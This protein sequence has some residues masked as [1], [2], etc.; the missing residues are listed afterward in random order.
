MIFY[1]TLHEEHK[2]D[3]SKI[4]PNKLSRHEIRLETFKPATDD[5]PAV[6]EQSVPETLLNM[7]LENKEHYQSKKEAIHL[8]LTGIGDE[9][10]STV[11]ACKTAYDMWITVEK[12]QQGESFNIQDVKTNLFWEFGKFT[13][14]DGESMKSYYSRSLAPQSKQSSFTRSNAPTRYKG[15]EI[16]KPITPPFASA[17]EEDNDPKQ[18]QRD[19]DMQKNLAL[20]ANYVKKLYKSTNNNLRTSSNSK[21]KNVDTTPRYLNENQTGQFGNQRIMT[22]DGAR[23]TIGSHVVQQTGIQC[24]NCKEFR[25]FVK[26]CRKPKRTKDYNYHKEKMLLCKQAEKGVPLQAEQADWQEDTDEEIDEQELE[27]HYG[28]MAKIQEVLPLESNSDAEPLEKVQYDENYNVFANERPHFEQPESINDTYAEEKVDSNVIPDSPDKCNNVNQADQNAEEC[29]DERA[30]LANLI[31]N[32]KLDT[33]E[34]KKIHK[35]L[36]KANATL[37]QQLQDCKYTLEE[38]ISSRDKCLIAL[39]VNEIKLKKY[40]TYL[41]R[42]IENE[43]LELERKLKETLGLLA[44]KEHEI[45]EASKCP[46]YNG[47]PTF[48]NPLYLKKAQSEKPCLYEIPYDQSHLANKFVPDREETLTLEQ[49]SRSN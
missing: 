1:P 13:S 2:D 18:A 23:E 21:N 34:N 48:A 12:L 37:A 44:Q 46:T 16:A 24:F 3:L 47:R 22:V 27:A 42:P 38:T 29:D 28:F 6:E 15:K 17:Y 7:S 41:N 11:D 35:Q 9:I 49:E 26:E 8:L 14:R 30:V 39:Q 32:F 20:I 10:Y 25:H 4:N 31:A 33:D 5:S 45:K 40:K 19:K 43:K 36:K